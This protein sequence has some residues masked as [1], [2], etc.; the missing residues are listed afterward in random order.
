MLALCRGDVSNDTCFVCVNYTSQAILMNCPQ[1]KQTTNNG[2]YPS[3]CI[4]RS[5]NTSFFDGKEKQPPRFI[6]IT[7]VIRFSV[8]EFDKALHSLVESLIIRAAMGSSTIKFAARETRFAG[9]MNLYGLMQCLPG[10]SSVDCR[11]CLRGAVDESRSFC[12]RERAV[13]VVRPNCIFQYDLTPSFDSSAGAAPRQPVNFAP[14][15]PPT[16]VTTKEDNKSRKLLAAI[17]VVVPTSILSVLIGSA[18]LRLRKRFKSSR[19][20]IPSNS[21]GNTGLTTFNVATIAEA[22]NNFSRSNKIGEANR[23]NP[24]TWSRWFDII[25]GIARGLVY[26]HRDSRLRIVHRD[27]K[28]SNVLLDDQM[29]PKIADFGLARAFRGDQ[30][31]EKTGK[32]V[33]TY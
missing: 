15:R 30:Q 17:F 27:L 14:P 7:G 20:Y 33:G 28:A 32:V 13:N 24:L 12:F 9:Y 29:N 10:I 21:D 25:V 22:T 8:D 2:D 19:T 11:R 31:L 5:S 1:D 23:S 16:N 18:F 4:V 26:L 6:S 3:K